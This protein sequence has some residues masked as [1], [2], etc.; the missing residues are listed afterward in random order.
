ME[1]LD[2]APVP[3]KTHKPHLRKCE[4][5]ENRTKVFWSTVCGCVRAVRAVQNAGLAGPSPMQVCEKPGLGPELAASLLG[6]KAMS[7]WKVGTGLAKLPRKGSMGDGGKVLRC[8]AS[9]ERPTH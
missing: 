2:C 8:Q 1:N 7:Y 3:V 6:Y 4:D 9:R 5:R